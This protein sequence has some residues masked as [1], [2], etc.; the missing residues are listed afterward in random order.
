[1][2]SAP[3]NKWKS[4]LVILCAISVASGRPFLGKFETEKQSVLIV[5]EEDTARLLQ[6]R[7]NMLMDKVE[8]LDIYF[9]IGKQIKLEE[10]FVDNLNRKSKIVNL[11]FQKKKHIQKKSKQNLLNSLWINFIYLQRMQKR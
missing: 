1:M 11:Q 7:C 9:H 5:N 10:E 8:P 6:E 4:W 3:P 2:I